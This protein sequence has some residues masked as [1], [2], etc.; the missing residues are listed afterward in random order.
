[1]S[2]VDEALALQH[3]RE[4]LASRFPTLDPT[5]VESVVVEV[6]ASLTG[7]VRDYVPLLVERASRDR[8]NAMAAGA[9]PHPRARSTRS[10]LASARGGWKGRQ[11]RLEQPAAEQ[12]THGRTPRTGGG[13]HEVDEHLCR[14]RPV[15]MG[16]DPV[17]NA[18]EEHGV[19]DRHSQGVQQQSAPLV[20]P[21]VEHP[22]S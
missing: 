12:L 14:D 13:C 8:L 1:M 4:V 15:S 11:L 9:S 20:D 19:A 5:T 3:L 10:K 2:G 7:P 16:L 18:R 6:H 17:P 21:V 22:C